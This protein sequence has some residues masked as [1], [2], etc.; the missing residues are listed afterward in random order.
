LAAQY[1]GFCGA[2]EIAIQM[3]EDD[4]LLKRVGKI[5]PTVDYQTDYIIQGPA[6]TSERVVLDCITSLF[7]TSGFIVD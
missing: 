5:S 7:K 6:A 1:L 2:E 3:E 4:V